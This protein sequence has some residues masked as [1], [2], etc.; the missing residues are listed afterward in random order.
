MKV[1]KE[2]IAE[3]VGVIEE[4]R[5][6]NSEQCTRVA[7]MEEDFTLQLEALKSMCK[8]LSDEK[9]ELEKRLSQ[10]N[11]NSCTEEKFSQLI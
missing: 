6:R 2:C 9:E 10:Q 11:R 5:T 7:Q 8:K 1:L 3:K 4:L